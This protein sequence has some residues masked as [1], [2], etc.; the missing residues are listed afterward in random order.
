MTPGTMP[1]SGVRF[2]DGLLT[3]P[4]LSRRNV[5]TTLKH[6][7]I[8]T[9]AVEPGRV[10]S[11]VHPRFDLETFSGEDGSVNALVSMVPF[12]ARD[13]RFLAAPRVKFRF[14][15]TNYRTYVIDRETRQRLVWFFGTSL[16]SWSLVVARHVWKL[17]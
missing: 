5:V 6:F 12:E 14:G 17:P 4:R 13:F 2:T 10:R 8:V 7:A 15:Q 1:S 9:Y 16:D 3:R 11:H